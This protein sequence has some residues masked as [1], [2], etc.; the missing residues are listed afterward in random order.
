[1]AMNEGPNEVVK[2]ETQ[3]VLLSP[4]D[5]DDVLHT[6]DA[7]NEREILDRAYKFT[8]TRPE[9]EKRFDINPELVKWN[10]AHQLASPQLAVKLQPQSG[11]K[12]LASNQSIRPTLKAYLDPL[13][14]QGAT[15]S[16]NP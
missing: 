2:E 3:E 12:P 11:T 5:Y 15:R 1:M 14:L 6:P 16:R 7:R 4:C 8:L 9:A 10:R 13:D